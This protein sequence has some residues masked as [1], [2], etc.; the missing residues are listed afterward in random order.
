MATLKLTAGSLSGTLWA[1]N[2]EPQP[3]SN[4][5]FLHIAMD[6]IHTTCV[7]PDDADVMRHGI[8]ASDGSL[9]L[10]HWKRN[11]VAM[12]A[13]L[14][15]AVSSFAFATHRRDHIFCASMQNL[16]L[17]NL[18]TCRIEKKTHAPHLN[19]IVRTI[20][21]PALPTTVVSVSSDTIA[22]WDANQLTCRHNTR[23]NLR[24]KVTPAKFIDAALS[25]HAVFA[26]QSL[27]SPTCPA[28]TI[29]A[30]VKLS[31]NT[32]DVVK[33][34]VLGEDRVPGSVVVV[35][36]KSVV[37]GNSA[38]PE[39]LVFDS[40]LNSICAVM[41]PGSAPVKKVTVVDADLIAAQT[42]DG[43]IWFVVV[44]QHSVSF[45]LA[46]PFSNPVVG[47]AS[48]HA[49]YVTV[50][51]AGEVYVYHLPS[52]KRFCDRTMTGNLHHQAVIGSGGSTTATTVLPFVKT[53]SDA[54]PDVAAE[55]SESY[56]AALP[57]QPMQPDEAVVAS[58]WVKANLVSHHDAT[59]GAPRTLLLHDAVKGL[60]NESIHKTGAAASAVQH[61]TVA[62]PKD[63][64]GHSLNRAAA[65]SGKSDKN[66]ATKK[67]SSSSSA[68]STALPRQANIT[69]RSFLD[70]ESRAVNMDKLRVML[71]R[72][73]MYPEKYRT[74]IWRFLL[75]LP[76]KRFLAP[77][78]QALTEKGAHP[79]L[80][81]LMEPFPLPRNKQRAT[82][83]AALSA[84]AWN[85]PVLSVVHFVPNLVFPFVQ[86]YGSDTQSAIEVFMSVLTN[87]G[88]EFFTYYPHHPVAILSFLN[89]TL[90]SEDL[91]LH[92]HLE[93][94][95]VS[96]ENWGW[97]VLRSLYTEVLT[98][99]EWLQVMDHAFS[100]EPIWLF[101]FHVR[102]IIQLREV[103][104]QL[105]D[106]GQHVAMFRKTTPTNINTMI[107]QTYQLRQRCPLGTIVEPYL[108]FNTFREFAYPVV[109]ECD[110]AVITT[111]LRE[112]ERIASLQEE[113]KASQ[114]LV[115]DIKSRI[116]QAAMLEDAFVG[117]QRA[118]VAA[119]M[120]ATNESWVQQVQLEK[121]R[122]R[123]RDIEHETRL[124][125]MQEQLRS[126]QRLEGLQHE[127]NAASQS[128]RDADV[129]RRREVT[130]WDFSD[131][132]SAQ[133]MTRLEAGARLKLQSMLKTTAVLADGSGGDVLQLAVDEHAVPPILPDSLIE[134]HLA[135]EQL[136]KQQQQQASAVP[137]PV[138][139]SVRAAQYHH[140]RHAAPA[141]H[142]DS[143]TMTELPPLPPVPASSSSSC[144][145]KPASHDAPQPHAH[146]DVAEYDETEESEAPPQPPGSGS[147][148]T[149]ASDP[150][151]Y[152]QQLQRTIQQGVARA[153]REQKHRLEALE[154]RFAQHL[155]SEGEEESGSSELTE[156]AVADSTSTAET[157]STNGGSRDRAQKT[158]TTTTTTVR[159]SMQQHEL[160]D[161]MSDEVVVGQQQ[162]HR[163][164]HSQEQRHHM[165]HATDESCSLLA[166][167]GASTSMTKALLRPQNPDFFN[168]HKKD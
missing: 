144:S 7:A 99:N 91:E 145:A 135:A 38:A 108:T 41:L 15:Q 162:Q 28:A 167:S 117:K 40:D 63:A 157:S 118:M 161:D 67:A 103:L 136:R 27:P 14:P 64:T 109:L 16:F 59:S 29:G 112:L 53:A 148:S 159:R 111:K 39:L 37:V 57:R 93:E 52:V 33:R 77:Q 92:Q 44:S 116:A 164:R 168:F 68:P 141:P 122:Q 96:V 128:A 43:R 12:I 81:T 1:S 26:A 151:H 8:G 22:L 4:G 160:H 34:V 50:A 88:K 60:H 66:A 11:R 97:E 158:T 13:K 131:R 124:M 84:L 58:E 106:Y 79:G 127:V 126:A 137:P 150:L 110:E 102:W 72:Y 125:A 62:A 25:E 73:G 134:E 80:E 123:L 121:E 54:T 55:L 133:E 31:S 70:H 138:V 46:L 75:Q 87:W 47:I 78:Y 147:T 2:R 65:S 146:H 17:V 107:H 89:H 139:Q 132:M 114:K 76:E 85:S 83:E 149:C 100:N 18:E 115:V 48:S 19:Q 143:Q 113:A 86:L 36:S 105:H 74:L 9:F 129:D 156:V 101:L 10:L 69:V 21:H 32:L 6:S 20:T 24:S 90:K 95:G 154:S 42:A 71:M 56:E 35:N 153:Q 130:K 5:Q 98:R 82:F 3:K 163:L 140:D 142:R 30:M 61:K 49:T 166:S 104:L 120:E 152:Y 155:G 119:K 165:Q 45:S 94:C 23:E 51:T